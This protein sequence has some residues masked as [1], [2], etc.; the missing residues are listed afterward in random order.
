VNDDDEPGG[1]NATERDAVDERT[2][3]D[4]TDVRRAGAS[5]DANSVAYLVTC[6][7]QLTVALRPIAIRY[8]GSTADERRDIAAG[9]EPLCREVGN[10]GHEL[11]RTMTELLLGVS[12]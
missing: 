11:S 3:A 8:D 4:T 2:D 6:L 5:P 1:N 9:L 10:V 12:K 7:E